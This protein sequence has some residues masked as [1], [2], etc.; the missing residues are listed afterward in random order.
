MCDFVP[1]GRLGVVTLEREATAWPSSLAVVPHRRVPLPPERG[2]YGLGRH[3]T[4]ATR[5]P[6]DRYVRRVGSTRVADE[7][8]RAGRE[9]GAELLWMPLVGTTTLAIAGT[10]AKTLG[11]PLVTM[12]WDPPEYL[13]SHSYSLGGS[14]LD[15]H[16]EAFGTALRASARCAVMSDAMKRCYETRFGTPCVILRFGVEERLWRTKAPGPRASEEF[17]IGYAG[18]IY[19]KE[20][21]ASLLAAL[22][23]VGWNLVGRNIVLRVFAASVDVPPAKGP[24]RIDFRGWHSVEST[25]EELRR[26]DLGYLPYWFDDRYRVAVQQSFPTKFSTY[27]AAGCPVFYHGPRDASPTAFLERYPAGLACHSTEAS[28][29]VEALSRCVE[30][31]Q[32]AERSFRITRTA[33]EEELGQQVFRD[34]FASLLGVDAGELRQSGS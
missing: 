11:V 1:D 3:V 15:R 2:F 14:L 12:V 4:R 9:L 23:S 5:R 8:I 32:L 29:I 7:V 33:M 18:S 30:D 31:R 22:D 28:D 25:L 16:L 27:F 6:V 19:A 20:E 13:L 10:V 26:V 24:V 34:R 17:V 21:W